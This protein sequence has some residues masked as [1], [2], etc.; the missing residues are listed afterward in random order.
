MADSGVVRFPRPRRTETLVVVAAAL[1]MLVAIV[2]VVAVRLISAPDD[3]VPPGVSIGGV[4]VG[5]LSADEA[6]RAV[7]AGAVAPAGA[8][9]LELAGEPGFP[10]SVPL[11]QLA[12]VPRAHAAV[13]EALRRPSFTGRV[14]GEVGLERA[15]AVALR[16]RATPARA[17]AVAAEIAGRIDTPPRAASL[18]VAGGRV[19][20]TPAAAGRGVDAARLT[21]LLTALPARAAVPVAPVPPAV[22][23]AQA[24]AARVEAERIA[25]TPVAVRGAG[26]RATIPRERLLAALRFAP[27]PAGIV[28]TLAPE[29]LAAA[30]G[31]AFAGV[32]REARS[33]DFQVE[34]ARV[35]VIAGQDGRSLDAAALA[36]RV[37]RRTG[38]APVALPI[39]SEAP[40]RTT[41]QAEQMGISARVSTFTTPHACCQPR[42]TNINRAAAILDGTIIP[43][44][45]TFSLNEAL[46]ER[47]KARGFVA[48][49]QING[50]QLEDAIGGG[51]SQMATTV[52]NAAFF[53]GLRIVV[54][55]PHEFWITRYP[56]GREAT[57]SWGGPELIVE[58]DWPAAVLLKVS[59]ADASLTVS[60]Y[61]SPLGRRVTT[62]SSGDAV[63][64]T[65]FTETVTRK[66]WRGATLRRD[67]TFRWT[68]KV[69]PAGH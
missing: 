7:R 37:Q 30:V 34:G 4:A 2:V 48:A 55:T 33:A 10:V 24:E 16:F 27:G 23:D 40:A 66:V 36:R 5:G 3:R 57:V 25:A 45:A 44:G 43:A 12:P 54:H 20:A 9:E 69:P 62:T 14:L 50:G 1:A 32:L 68:Y 39:V 6:E 18:R 52:F 58:N 28:V 8:V 29:V 63:A 15:R 61:S 35:R 42:V 60:M 59:G 64:G 11:S 13:M 65:A 67:E 38:T 26:R 51:V 56:P 31:P 47:T 17:R 46:G 53:A 22:T 19:V 49:P 41:R 21:A